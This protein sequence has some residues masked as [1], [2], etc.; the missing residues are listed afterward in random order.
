MTKQELEVKLLTLLTLLK[1]KCKLLIISYEN[2][3]PD[4][5]AA[6][7]GLKHLSAR[8]AYPLITRKNNAPGVKDSGGD[9]NS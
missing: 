1:G 5:I 6:A 4:G 9:V 8:Q 2:T 7:F 3:D